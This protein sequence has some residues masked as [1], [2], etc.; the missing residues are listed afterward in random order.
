MFSEA[1]FYRISDLNQLTQHV[2]YRQ[3]FS[4]IC[5]S[6]VTSQRALMQQEPHHPS[7]I[8]LLERIGLMIQWAESLFGSVLCISHMGGENKREGQSDSWELHNTTEE[9][10]REKKQS[11]DGEGSLMLQWSLIYFR[12]LSVILYIDRKSQAGRMFFFYV[13]ITETK[14][15]YWLCPQRCIFFRVQKDH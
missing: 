8:S 9:Q 5:C 3:R 11:W 15:I 1:T 10:M 2:F 4:G 12:R 14:S 6:F 7:T 13:F